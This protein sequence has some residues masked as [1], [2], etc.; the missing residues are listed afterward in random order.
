MDDLRQRLNKYLFFHI[1][2]LGPQ[3]D[4]DKLIAKIRKLDLTN[5]K[6]NLLNPYKKD[7]DSKIKGN[8]KS[9]NSNV[10]SNSNNNNNRT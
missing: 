9:Q 5:R 3:E 7:R 6:I 2:R 8:S 10:G 1:Y 4:I